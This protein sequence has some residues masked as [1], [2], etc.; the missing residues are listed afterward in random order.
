MEFGRR[1]QLHPIIS[2]LLHNG[3]EFTTIIRSTV[4]RTTIRMS[5]IN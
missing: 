2:S 4:I 1:L 5:T 3:N